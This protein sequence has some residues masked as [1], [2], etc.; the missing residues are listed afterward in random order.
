MRLFNRFVRIVEDP[1]EMEDTDD[2]GPE[3][4]LCRNRGPVQEA[5]VVNCEALETGGPTLR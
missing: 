2:S 3:E 1:D 4:V 5:Q